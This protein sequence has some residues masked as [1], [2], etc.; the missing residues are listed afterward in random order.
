MVVYTVC[1]LKELLLVIMLMCIFEF[2]F[3]YCGFP[4]EQVLTFV[5]YKV[6]FCFIFVSIATFP[7]YV[8]FCCT[9][10]TFSSV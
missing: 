10:G 6:L 2:K 4:V 5:L 8:Y 3:G 1:F 7:F 9:K